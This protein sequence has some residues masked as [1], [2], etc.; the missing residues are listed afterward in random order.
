[1]PDRK[2]FEY[3]VKVVNFQTSEEGVEGLNELGQEGWELC[4]VAGGCNWILK[5]E[6]LPPAPVGLFDS[7]GVGF[8]ARPNS[9]HWGPHVRNS[10]CLNWEAVDGEA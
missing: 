10:K 4:M 3:K 8:C 1:M 9:S 6:I 2:K 5:R 7:S